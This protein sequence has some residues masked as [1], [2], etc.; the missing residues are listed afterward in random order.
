MYQLLVSSKVWKRRANSRMSGCI[1]RRVLSV[2]GLQI[3]RGPIKPELR[4]LSWKHRFNFLISSLL[5]TQQ[6]KVMTI[7]NLVHSGVVSPSFAVKF[8]VCGSLSLGYP[9]RISPHLSRG[10]RL[11]WN[12]RK[13]RRGGLAISHHLVA[14]VDS[15]KMEGVW[16][17]CPVPKDDLKHTEKLMSKLPSTHPSSINRSLFTVAKLLDH[18]L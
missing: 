8:V 4:S 15:M 11:S 10:Q 17:G 1:C 14:V 16:P 3:T 2:P 7:Q 5:C 13:G 18:S 6:K 9:P 12:S